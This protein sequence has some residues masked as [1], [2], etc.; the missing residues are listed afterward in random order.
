MMNRFDELGGAVSEPSV[1]VMLAT[2]NGEMFVADQIE[3][4]L[5]QRGVATTIYV[6][7]DG[8][9]DGTLEIVRSLSETHPGR[10]VLLD[11]APHRFG[12]AS[13]NFFSMLADVH[14]MPHAYFAFSD[15]DDI[16][17]PEKLERA[18]GRLTE[19]GA[20]GY[21][22]NL[23]AFSEAR[24]AE[25]TM[26]KA[27]PQRRFDHLFQAASAGCTYVFDQKA[28]ELIAMRIGRV[29]D[30]DWWGVSHDWLC[31]AI[32]RSHGL[33]WVIDDWSGIRYRQHE[34]NF[35]GA[36]SGVKGALKR[37][38]LMRE[39][40]YRGTVV[41]NRRFL[42]PDNMAERPVLDRMARLNV[43]DRLWLAAHVRE[44]RR[45]PKAQLAL[46]AALISGLI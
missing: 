44:L 36:Q 45:E 38:S 19:S 27:D 18:V 10:I 8:S 23:T 16:W 21:A 39:G 2:Y 37:L 6:R 12:T 9:S 32:C 46:A 22:S 25:W 3:S 40:W 15:Q 31:Y 28:A 5:G 42:D 20:S 4:I 29:D 26:A 17:L 43:G 33:A 14:R 13:G 34:Q 24:G 11:D 30:Q 1:G 41:R 35:F 7:D